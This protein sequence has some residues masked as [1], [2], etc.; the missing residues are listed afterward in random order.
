MNAGSFSS[1]TKSE[2]SVKFAM[3]FF[4]FLDS[5]W[6]AGFSKK[7]RLVTPTSIRK[8]GQLEPVAFL[9]A[10]K[11]M[12]VDA[13]GAVTARQSPSSAAIE[14]QLTLHRTEFEEIVKHFGRDA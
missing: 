13:G 8:H 5:S 7:K 14:E 2:S 10:W 12:V 1:V 9:H 4:G 11:A 3:V 6:L